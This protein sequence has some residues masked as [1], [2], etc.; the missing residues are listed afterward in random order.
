M[1]IALCHFEL[2]ARETGLG[3][4]WVVEDPGLVAAGSG[5]EYTATWRPA[6]PMPPVF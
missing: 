6:P 3:G 4:A 1:G 2:V 5:C